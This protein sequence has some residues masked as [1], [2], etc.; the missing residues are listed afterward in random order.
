MINPKNRYIKVNGQIVGKNVGPRPIVINTARNPQ[1][2]ANTQRSQRKI[3]E[4][5]RMNHHRAPPISKRNPNINNVNQRNQGPN[6]VVFHNPMINNQSLSNQRP[7]V[8]QQPAPNVHQINMLP[9]PG[10]AKYPVIN[11]E[12]HNNENNS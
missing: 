1:K 7:V 5:N 9:P 10:P 2:Y 4:N 11:R 6:Q 12:V 3:N 8:I